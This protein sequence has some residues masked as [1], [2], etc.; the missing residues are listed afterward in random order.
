M[1]SK[2]EWKIQ[3]KLGGSPGADH[4][5]ILEHKYY[6]TLFF[7][8]FWLAPQILNSIRILKKFAQRKIYEAKSL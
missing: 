4:I 7:Q 3:A 1:A 2:A 6:A 5:M 8:A